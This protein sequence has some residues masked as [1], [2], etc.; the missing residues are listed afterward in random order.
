M[1][2][3]SN[4]STLMAAVN[5][6]VNDSK[7]DGM[8]VLAWP[9]SNPSFQI[10]G[11]QLDG[12]YALVFGLDV[13]GREG[14]LIIPAAQLAIHMACEPDKPAV[15]GEVKKASFGFIRFGDETQ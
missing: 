8:R 13:A 7:K 1:K 3:D 10:A 12:A 11:I 14:M 15:I 2:A 5:R 6:F 9:L 4:L